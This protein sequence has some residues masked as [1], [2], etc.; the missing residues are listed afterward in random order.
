M[1]S[2]MIL[3]GSA[4]S[5]SV[6]PKVTLVSSSSTTSFQVGEVFVGRTSGSKGRIIKQSG[7]ELYFVYLSTTNFIP[8]ETLFGYASSAERSISTI[9]SHGL[10]NIKDRYTL[11]DGQ[12]DQAFNFSK[13][14]KVSTD[15]AI[16][17][18]S[19]LV[20]IFDH[21][22]TENNDGVFASVESFYDADY[23]DIPSY[24]YGQEKCYLS[25]IIDWRIDAESTLNMSGGGE[26]A[27]PYTIDPTK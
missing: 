7:N 16:S 13:L 1:Q 2:I 27:T 15:S 25:D 17:E 18:T 24:E 3:L 20:V 11:D 19:K 22:K 12:G 4:A 5:T 6:V 21:F 26:I 14:V 10:P 23:D 8:N 9:N